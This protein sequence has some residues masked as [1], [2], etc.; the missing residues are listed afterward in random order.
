VDFWFEKQLETL[1]ITLSE[2]MIWQFRQYHDFLLQKNE[3]MN[4][5]AI[6]GETEIYRK[7]FL[8]S[9]SLVLAFTPENQSLLDVG[10]GAGFPSLP[11]K[12]VFP[13]LKVTILDSLGKRIG[14]LEELT[15]RLGLK[16]VTLVWGRAEEFGPKNHFDLV[17]ARAVARLDILTEL[18]LPFVR[19]SGLFLAMK[20]PDCDE[21]I[22]QASKAIRT[23]GG[24]LEKQITVPIDETVRHQLI[25]VRK[26]R[27]T[28][29]KYPRTY[30][31]IKK[32]PL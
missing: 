22:R 8:D 31:Q 12:I 25:V 30:A 2:S 10:S 17:T 5:T 13:N 26:L 32:K 20:G 21:E 6:T 23:L 11:L 19:P 29:G 4:L 14:F 3:F 24:A 27:E 16:D 28:D 7:H 1:K 15:G 18:C 9:L